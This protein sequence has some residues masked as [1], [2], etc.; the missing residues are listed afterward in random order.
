MG[1]V[2]LEVLFVVVEDEELEEV[3]DFLGLS[4]CLQGPHKTV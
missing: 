3:Y 1:L 2:V 4:C